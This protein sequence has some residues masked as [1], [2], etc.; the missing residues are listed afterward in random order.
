WK[1]FY[2]MHQP[3]SFTK[4]VWYYLKVQTIQYMHAID[5]FIFCASSSSLDELLRL[6]DVP[7]W[8]LWKCRLK[9]QPPRVQTEASSFPPPTGS[10]RS[11][12]YAPTSF[13]LEILKGLTS[14]TG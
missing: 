7:D 3:D 8:K 6:T 13:S 11:A 14:W 1:E 12:Q 9:L 5:L 10:H 2:G 4:T